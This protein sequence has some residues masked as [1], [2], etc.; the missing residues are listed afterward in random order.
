MK[1]AIITRKTLY[2]V[3]GGD[4]FQIIN[5]A[6]QLHRL[7]I[8]VDIKLTHEPVDYSQYHLLHFFNIVRPADILYHIRQANKPFVISPNLVNYQEYDRLYRQCLAGMLFSKLSK[9]SI[10]YLKTI[11]RWVQGSDVLQTPSYVWQGHKQSIQKILRQASRILPNSLLEFEQLREYG[12]P[13]P[14]Y[15]VVPNGIDPA[16]FSYSHD[17]NK[18]AKLVLC[19]ARIEGLK[20]QLNLI[21]AL[22]NTVYKLVIIGA[23]APNQP[24]YYNECKRTAAANVSFIEHL[25]QNELVPW[26]QK[27]GV[28]I[29]PSWFET[30]GLSSLEAAAMGCSVVITEKGYT[31]EYFNND[32]L[33]CEPGSPQSI[34][35]AVEQASAKTTSE[36]LRQKILHHYTWEQAAIQ[37][38]TAYKQVLLQ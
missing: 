27:A 7:G 10:E 23:P 26:Y 37:T 22:N 6:R 25:S 33:Y 38:A 11:A 24:S 21:K 18:D 31:R 36:T 8:T 29:L 5:T 1:V 16:L 28:H 34:L 3:R 30:C 20:N 32:A 4:T 35:Q 13:L 19:V 14:P 17:T 9:N 12:I 2:S 15:T